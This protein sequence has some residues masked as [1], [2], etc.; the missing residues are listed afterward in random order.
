MMENTWK[1]GIMAR[2][3]HCTWKYWIVAYSVCFSILCQ[4]R[5][6]TLSTSSFLNREFGGWENLN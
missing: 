2:G 3:E 5:V 4:K 1:Y 6:W